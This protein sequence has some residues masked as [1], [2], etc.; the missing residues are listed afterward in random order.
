MKLEHDTGETQIMVR[1]EA[2]VD[3]TLEPPVGFSIVNV[4]HKR[5]QQ[6]YYT[7]HNV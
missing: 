6:I 7:I 4:I 3:A 1:S 5:T 2:S